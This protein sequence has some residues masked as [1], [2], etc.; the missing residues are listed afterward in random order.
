MTRRSWLSLA[1]AAQARAASQGELYALTV[2]PWTQ[3]N[4]RHDH[5]QILPLSGGR[6][7]LVWS[8]YYVRQPSK[9]VRTP[10]SQGGA[11][12][13][14]PS[15]L[16]GKISVDR[17]RTWSENLT[18]Q[19]NVAADCV[20]HP[21]LLRLRSGE[22]LMAY[23]VRNFKTHDSRVFLRRST[24]ECETWSRPEQITPDGGFWLINCDHI[25]RHSSGRVI[26]PSY[27]SPTIWDAKEHFMA[28]ALYSDDEGRTWKQS[29]NRMD[30]PKRGA[31]EPGI[32]EL[33]N[34][35]LYSILRTSLGRIYSAVSEDR[36]ETWSEP[37]PTSLVAPASQPCIRRIPGSGEL[38]VLF[39]N[40][41]DPAHSHGGVRNP[42]NS[43][44]SRDEG[45]TWENIKTVENWSD[46]DSAYP[47]VTFSGNEALITYYQR[48]RAMSRDTHLQL[49]IFASDWFTAP[50]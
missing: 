8:E 34:G 17:G 41:Y 27:W 1:A 13:E 26:L 25:L 19:E 3:R 16:S 31:E 42:L 20:K 30:L 23:T 45:K 29:K 10:Y 24:D 48:S 12:D 2:C 35:A 28:F 7:L 40:T 21:N 43:A 4:P 39:N 38:L 22:I 46:H 37:K 14:A 44:I 33:K 9:I 5:A 36:G 18:L 32:V 47:S 6:L 49:K 15:Q 11:G 50:D